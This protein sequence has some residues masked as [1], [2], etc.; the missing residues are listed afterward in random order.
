MKATAPD[1]ET[2][3]GRTLLL[4]GGAGSGKTHL[5]RAFRT[6]AHQQALAYFAYMQMTTSRGSYS[7]YILHK[8]ID[9]LD[10]P[11]YR[12]PAN[13]DG[14]TG[15]LRLSTAV[16]ESPTLDQEQVRRLREDHLQHSECASLVLD[17]A[18]DAVRNP[19]LHKIPVDLVMAMLFL[20][21]GDPAI[22]NRVMKY[23]RAEAL[24]DHDRQRLGGIAPLDRDESAQTMIE[25][26][27]HLMWSMHGASLIIC[28]DQME[29]VSVHD[30]AAEKF[31]R[32][33]NGLTQISAHVPSSLV[34][35][36]CDRISSR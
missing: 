35:I 11:Y 31:R 32:A 18:D 19:A 9:S 13:G 6:R 20:Q 30:G 26:L 22:R 23:L 17:L 1:N 2:K 10:V 3:V 28:V 25:R 4:L 21:S 15:L 24:S 36:A 5:M 16:A 29:S 7:R 27:G 33:I 14:T 12:T 34:V 8:L